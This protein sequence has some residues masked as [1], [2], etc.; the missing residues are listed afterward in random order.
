M[1]H[2]ID[3]VLKFVKSDVLTIEAL[4]IPVIT[5]KIDISNA[6]ITFA[7]HA[8]ANITASRISKEVVRKMRIFQ[9]DAY[10]ALDFHKRVIEVIRL[11]NGI[12]RERLSAAGLEEFF[13]VDRSVLDEEESLKNELI[14]FVESVRTGR[15][16]EAT[17][18]DGRKALQVAIK[19]LD[20][21]KG[22]S[23]GL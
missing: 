18:E 8:V 19:I 9:R 7:N 6:R 12:D 5:D 14:S 1:I 16:P 22:V 11:N 23:I 15:E 2:D 20:T 4:G 13:V 10:I 21:I 17:G 3:L